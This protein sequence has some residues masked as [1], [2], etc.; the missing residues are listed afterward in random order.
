MK[1]RMILA[2]LLLMAFGTV[3]AQETLIPTP[4]GDGSK[5]NTIVLKGSGTLKLRQGDKLTMN[6]VGSGVQ[7]CVE[8]SVLYLMGSGSREVTIPNLSYLE[9]SVGASSVQ[10]KSGALRG[11]NLSIKKMGS[12]GIVDLLVDYD[13][14]YVRSIG[15]NVTLSGKCNVF[16]SEV[17]GKGRVDASKLDYKAKVEK[18][19]D[20]WNMAFNLDDSSDKESLQNMVKDAQPFFEA[21][22]C[23]SGSWNRMAGDK[24]SYEALD[25]LQLKELMRE[26]GVNLQQLSDSVDWEK[27][28]QDM[29]RWGADME[30]W[31]RKMEKWADRYERK[32]EKRGDSHS[33]NYDYHYEYNN[34]RPEEKEEKNDGSKDTRPEKKNL[35]LDAHWNGFEAG[36]NMLFNMP[37][38]A[39]NTSNAAQGM[40]LRPL[41]SWYFGFNIADVGIAFNRKHTVGLFT[42]VGIGWNNFSW[43][44]D[45][46]IEYDPENVVYTI[47]PIDPNRVVKNT[48]N[49][50]LFLQ[51][52]L[53]FEIRPTRKM[54]IDAGVTGGLRIAQWNRV[55]F[56]DGAQVKNYY[57]ARVNQFKLDASLRVGGR[58][59]GF[60]ANYAIL[61]MFD[62]NDAKVHPLSFGFSINF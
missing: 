34:N 2:A 53:M 28:E 23:R 18:S 48:K 9:I 22:T 47:V 46:T 58:N 61:P 24:S 13:N 21:E 45:I 62:M 1:T 17:L 40:G 35:L 42:G 56:A 38:G 49:G 52:P 55:K 27:F 20:R 32:M 51:V 43:N 29:E 5:I 7:Y 41:R 37:V 54:Y 3:K 30:E 15:G 39:A 60:F 14:V 10:M 8:D 44:K 57:T 11:K 50:T 16:C 19:G 25:T 31:G 4:D 59:L 33:R 26:L 6:V 36:L 12:S